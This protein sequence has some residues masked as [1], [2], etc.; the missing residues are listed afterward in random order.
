MTI[1]NLS[2]IEAQLISLGL[3]HILTR[4]LSGP[5][6]E[7]V[8]MNFSSLRIAKTVQRL[9]YSWCWFYPQVKERISL[10]LKEEILTLIIKPRG[11]P[12]QRGRKGGKV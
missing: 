2:L 11:L 10:T 12:E 5:L 1:R 6:S 9:L 8:E 7:T 4:L 3:T